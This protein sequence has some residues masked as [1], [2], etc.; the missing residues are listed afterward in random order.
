MPEAELV[1]PM[2]HSQYSSLPHKNTFKVED[3]LGEIWDQVI[4]S[5]CERY[6]LKFNPLFMKNPLHS[7]FKFISQLT[8]LMEMILPHAS[9]LQKHAIDAKHDK[10]IRFLEGFPSTLMAIAGNDNNKEARILDD[11]DLNDIL[12]LCSDL[13]ATVSL[14]LFR[15]F[16][17]MKDDMLIVL[18]SIADLTRSS[19]ANKNESSLLPIV[20]SGPSRIDKCL[21][22]TKYINASTESNAKGGNDNTNETPLVLC[23]PCNQIGGLNVAGSQKVAAVG[24]RKRQGGAW[25]ED[26]AFSKP[27][28]HVY[29]GY[30]PCCD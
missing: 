28:Q 19:N 30:C 6:E 18:K 9:I 26:V 2:L 21:Y 29:N 5:V 12:E 13:E 14:L 8:Y 16:G 3:T 1:L 17:S 25:G 24:K 4:L 20:D 27:N 15:Q 11:S 23:L 7:V 10:F 22:T